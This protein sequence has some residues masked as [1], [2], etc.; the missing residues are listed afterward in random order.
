MD[1]G[2][3]KFLFVS[4]SGL[5]SDIAWQVAKEGHEVKYF[6]EDVEGA[7]YRRRLRAQGRRLGARTSTG[8]TS[9]CSTT[10]LG[11]GA[12]AQALRAGRQA[13]GR[14]HALHRPAGGR[15]LLRPGRAEEGRHQHPALSRV[16][17]LR[18]R[19]R[20]CE[21][22]S[23]ALR[24]Q[25]VGRC[26]QRQAAAVRRRRGRRRRCG[27]CARSLQEVVSRRDQ[28]VP[29]P[30]PRHRRRGRGRRVLQRQ[31]VRHADQRQLR[32]QEAL[33]REHRSLHR[34]DGHGDVLERRRTGCSTQL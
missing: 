17:Q 7:R 20:V 16:R 31:G 19:D 5:I 2:K 34:R 24:H 9:S 12:K 27:P 21:E 11:Q 3:R 29:A 4:L 10:R 33:P 8:P 15:S 26:R 25:A 23:G 30:A 13:C 22:Q 6:I 28:G 14:R 18:R 1:G 32:A